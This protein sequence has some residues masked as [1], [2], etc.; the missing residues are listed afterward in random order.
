MAKTETVWRVLGRA[1]VM[2]ANDFGPLVVLTTQL[3]RT[4]SEADR[5]LRAAGPG[6]IH[7]AVDLL[8]DG[9]RRRLAE[10]AS[11]RT[12]APL[13]GFWSPSDVAPGAV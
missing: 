4:G 8:A 11:G 3:P 12:A 1:H 10:Y 2:A 7:D 6:G 9:A 13:A 5:A